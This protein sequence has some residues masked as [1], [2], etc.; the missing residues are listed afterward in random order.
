[1]PSRINR[2]TVHQ[3]TTKCRVYSRA[4]HRPCPITKRAVGFQ[5]S[6][7]ELLRDTDDTP[8]RAQ[9][10]QQLSET[11]AANLDVLDIVS[12][13]PVHGFREDL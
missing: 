13:Y 6:S 10:R 9:L 5:Q 11:I 4:I 12:S 8:R 7:P 3:Y 1:M 2:V